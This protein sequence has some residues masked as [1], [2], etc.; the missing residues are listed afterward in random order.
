MAPNISQKSQIVQFIQPFGIIDHQR[1]GRPITICD[2][3]GKRVF[4]TGDI[5]VNL[6]GCQ[7]RALIRPKAGIAHF[8]RAPTHQRNRAPTGFL[9]PAQH[10][11]LNETAYMQRV[12]GRIKANISGH[13]VRQ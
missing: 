1:I 7:Q 12:S 4:D 10:H 13:P 5:F 11:N 9:Q 2:I 3:R 6:G 8:R